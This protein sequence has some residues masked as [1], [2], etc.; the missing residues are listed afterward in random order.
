[1]P[2]QVPAW[3]Q[4]AAEQQAE[5][6]RRQ[7]AELEA[8]PVTE[9]AAQVEAR[10]GAERVAAVALT[11]R[12]EGLHDFTSDPSRQATGIERDGIGL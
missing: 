1:M 5:T 10:A 9:A 3:A 7:L 6:L 8:L 4:A 2:E 11:R 12:A